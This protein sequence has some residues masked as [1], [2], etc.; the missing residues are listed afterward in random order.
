MDEHTISPDAEDLAKL[1]TLATL[2]SMTPEQALK[3]ALAQ[4]LEPPSPIPFGAPLE[5]STSS[6]AP[7]EYRTWPAT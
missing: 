1:H 6:Q 5:G 2:W 4:A 7:V 3:R